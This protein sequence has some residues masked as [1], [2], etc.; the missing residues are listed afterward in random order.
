MQALIY[1]ELQMLLSVCERLKR[2]AVEQKQADLE[3]RLAA[4]EAAHGV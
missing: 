2:E 4:L 1:A 3:K